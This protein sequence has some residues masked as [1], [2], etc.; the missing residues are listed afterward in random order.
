MWTF[1]YNK[2][3]KKLFILKININSIDLIRKKKNNPLIWR[4]TIRGKHCPVYICTIQDSLADDLKP[5]SLFNFNG[6]LCSLNKTEFRRPTKRHQIL[7]SWN[8]REAGPDPTKH[9]LVKRRH[10]EIHS[11]EKDQPFPT[12]SLF[13]LCPANPN[14]FSFW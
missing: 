12:L 2:I 6:P 11:R 5:K 8:W 4:K 1:Y 9:A 7:S 10:C 13:P 14:F 3:H